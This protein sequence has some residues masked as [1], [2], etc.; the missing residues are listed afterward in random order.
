M[1][2]GRELRTAMKTGKV[3]LGFK[4]TIKACISG[5]A[6]LVIMA[7]N[8]P[9][10]IKKELSYYTKLSKTP[11]YVFPG[12]SWD[13]GGMCGKPFMVSSIA[14][15]DPGESDIL[16]LTELAEASGG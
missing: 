2:L 1:D 15:I 12:S 14:I 16:R 11:L 6:K 10:H 9:E 4:Q 7:Y 5:K 8:S 3:I 13:L